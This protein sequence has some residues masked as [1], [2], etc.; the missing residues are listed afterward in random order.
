MEEDK[1]VSYLWLIPLTLLFPILQ[2]I[3]FF[4]RFDRLPMD[5]LTSSLWFA[6]IGLISGLLLIYLSRKA[7]NI[8][9]KKNMVMG[10]I[11]ALPISIIFSLF[12]GL[13]IPPMFIFI[14]G[15][16]PLVIGI[17]LGYRIKA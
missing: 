5:I 6:P 1:K 12:Y 15:V 4:I 3:I 10:F 9:R 11:M 8:K 2:S 7:I 16:I 13:L 17:L 14:V